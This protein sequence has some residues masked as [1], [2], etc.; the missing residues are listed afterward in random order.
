MRSGVEHVGVHIMHQ[1]MRPE[2]TS[3]CG[4]KLLASE[5]LSYLLVCELHS[6]VEHVRVHFASD[7]REFGGELKHR[8][9]LLVVVHCDVYERDTQRVAPECRLRARR[10]SVSLLVVRLGVSLRCVR[11]GHRAWPRRRKLSWP[12]FRRC[13]ALLRRY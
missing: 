13:K 8:L 3:V 6:R 2:A 5:A 7:M 9:R 4:L 10:Y 12:L 1:C 11:A